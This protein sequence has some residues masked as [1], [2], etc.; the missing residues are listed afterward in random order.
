MCLVPKWE[1][2]LLVSVLNVEKLVFSFLFFFFSFF[3]RFSK[4]GGDWL[5]RLEFYFFWIPPCYITPSRHPTASPCHIPPSHH[6]VA[7]LSLRRPA[8]STPRYY[9]DSAAPMQTTPQWAHLPMVPLVASM[10]RCYGAFPYVYTNE[11]P[12]CRTNPPV[13][14][15]QTFGHTCLWTWLQGIIIY[16]KV[17]RG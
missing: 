1:W 13:K 15:Q 5:Y 16:L 12:F 6:P 17:R 7:P 2:L 11:R 10:P 3:F 14:L 9:N 4:N 8:A